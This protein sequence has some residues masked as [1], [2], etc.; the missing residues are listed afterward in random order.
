MSDK[1]EVYTWGRNSHAQLGIRLTGDDASYQF[2]VF[3][4]EAKAHVVRVLSCVER[5]GGEGPEGRGR[6]AE[7]LLCAVA[8]AKIEQWPVRELHTTH[9]TE[10]GHRHR[11]R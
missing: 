9:T 6:G 10:P 1:S 5:A 8:R 4:R 3:C 11:H 2:C 7:S